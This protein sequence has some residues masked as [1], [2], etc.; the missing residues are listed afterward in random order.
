MSPHLYPAIKGEM[1]D[2]TYYLTSLS[3]K[4]AVRHFKFA[5][6][7]V[8]FSDLDQII[9]RELSSRSNRIKGYLESNNQ[10]LFGALTV[11]VYGG[12]PQF[13]SITI[14]AS[15][16]LRHLEGRIGVL[17]FD[18]EEQ[19][20]V[21]DGQHRLAAM[22]DLAGEEPESPALKDEIS[23][24][25]VAHNRDSE[26]IQRARRLFTNL[27]RYAAKT[28]KTVNIVLDEDD[29]FSIIT[30]N[31]LRDI[32]FLKRFTKVTKST[33]SKSLAT[34]ESLSGSAD[35]SYLF[36]I[37]TF[38]EC[39]KGLLGSATPESFNEKQ[40]RPPDEDLETAF[41]ALAAKW[42][43]LF[44]HVD[45]LGT[46]KSSASLDLLE[47]RALQG[48]HVLARP[49]GIRSFCEAVGGMEPSDATWAKVK[50]VAQEFS[51]ISKE[52][53]VDLLWKRDGKMLFGKDRTNAAVGL[54]RFLLG[55]SVDRYR[56]ESNWLAIVDPDR[57]RGV[58]LEDLIHE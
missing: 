29:G 25:L 42:N 8:P 5:H 34:G 32:P 18:G 3:M 23:V 48:G 55:A 13:S 45:F 44:L 36:T 47:Q 40:L 4:E 19:Y 22:K 26:G 11:A 52:P 1:G 33:G 28:S 24:L 7:I 21:L 49:I 9:Q 6:E 54:W 31:L 16:V 35:K 20:Y 39:N 50:S 43:N 27:N 17:T 46:C 51:E 38:Y 56:V 14:E 10:R 57:T 12:Q 37:N 2:W 15:A 58:S 41:E 53:W 30:R